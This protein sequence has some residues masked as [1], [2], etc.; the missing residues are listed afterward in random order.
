MVRRSPNDSGPWDPGPLDP[1]AGDHTGYALSEVLGDE[2]AQPTTHENVGAVSRYASCSCGWTGPRHEPPDASS[3]LRVRRYRLHN[4]DVL[5]PD[6]QAH[7]DRYATD[8]IPE[9]TQTGEPATI[10]PEPE[11]EPEPVEPIEERL[12][13]A[14]A[15]LHRIETQQRGAAA[16]VQALVTEARETMTWQDVGDITGHSRQAAWDRWNPKKQQRSA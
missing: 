2:A 13:T 6:W 7:V 3:D 11:P 8:Q 14:W 10:E 5:R 4:R 16:T 1:G 9:C 15:E 12:R